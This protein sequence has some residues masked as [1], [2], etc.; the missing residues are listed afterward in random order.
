MGFSAGGH[1]AATLGTHFKNADERPSFIVLAYPVIS[2]TD[3]LT[4]NR[5]R[6][7]L[8]GKEITSGKIN[9]YSNELQV[10]GLTPGTFIVHA[11]DDQSV[12]VQNSLYFEAALLQHNVPVQ[13]FLYAHG[14]HGFGISNKTATVQ[15]IDGCIDWIKQ[16]K[17]KDTMLTSKDAV[18]RKG[19]NN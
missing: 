9:Y 18:V 6:S 7:E 2:M 4:H 19:P 15:W 13:L 12:K 3:S 5:S 1:L 14:G 10:T 8:L 17:W 11:I 16:M